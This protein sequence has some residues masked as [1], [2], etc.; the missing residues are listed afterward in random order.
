[1]TQRLRVYVCACLKTL[2]FV[3]VFTM[4]AI[5]IMIMMRVL[6]WLPWLLLANEFLKWVFY[7][8][9]LTSVHHVVTTNRRKLNLASAGSPRMHEIC[10]KFY[11]NASSGSQLKHMDG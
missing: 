1:M 10:I 2:T 8:S 7:R 9:Y 3:G 6:L 4:V 11:K 5:L